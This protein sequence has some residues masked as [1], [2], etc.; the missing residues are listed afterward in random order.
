LGF[1]CHDSQEAHLLFEGKSF[2]HD[3][4]DP[5]SLPLVKL[6]SMVGKNISDD[7]LLSP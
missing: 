5:S 4:G 7:G 1:E 6:V 2:T 3:V